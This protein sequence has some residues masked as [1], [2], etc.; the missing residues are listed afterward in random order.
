[1][2]AVSGHQGPGKT[3][4]FV[5]EAGRLYEVTTVTQQDRADWELTH[6][7]WPPEYE[8]T[9]AV[10]D[11]EVKPYSDE[12]TPRGFSVHPIWGGVTPALDRPQGTGWVVAGPRMRDRLVRAIVAGV[13]HGEPVIMRDV[14]GRTYV[15]ASNKVLGRY[16]N[17]DLKRLGY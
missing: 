3:E 1:V 6:T 10:V 4:L 13:V 7:V 11:V 2:A 9:P 14:H 16:M 12:Y 5:T 17:A 15:Q 8:G